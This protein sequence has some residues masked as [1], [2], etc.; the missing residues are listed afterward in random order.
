MSSLEF[1]VETIRIFSS[2]YVEALLEIEIRTG[3]ID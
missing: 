3:K 2:E 1:S